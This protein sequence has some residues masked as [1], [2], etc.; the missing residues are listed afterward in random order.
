[1]AMNYLG[2]FE[3]H[4][5]N[6][7]YPAFLALWE[8]YC[9]GDEADGEELKL[10]LQKA[11]VAPLAVPFGRHVDKG[12]ALW[13]RL[14]GTEV[15][16]DVFKLIIDLVTTNTP[17]L[18]RRIFDYL[19][20]KYPDDPYFQDK[21]R[22]IGLRDGKEFQGAV[23]NY[24]LLTHMKKG[25]FVFHN[26]G[27]G[28]GEIMEISFIREQLALEFDYVS[29]CKDLSFQNAFKTLTPLSGDHFL[30]LRFGKPDELEAHARRDSVDVIRILLRDL[31]PLTAAEIKEELH[32][33]VIP[34]EEWARWWQTTRTKIKKSTFIEVPKDMRAPFRLRE[35]EISHKEILRK[36]LEAD[37]KPEKVIGTVYTFLRDFPSVLKEEELRTGLE[38]KLKAFLRMEEL[39]DAVAL[40]IY[41]LLQDSGADKKGEQVHELIRRLVAPDDVVATI[42]I[43][44]FKKR[45]LVVIRSYRDDWKELFLNL[46]LSLDQN[47]LRDYLLSELL[48]V[49]ERDGVVGKLE[50]MLNFPMR[51][52]Y[53][54]L[55]YFKR[56][57]ESP[58]LPFADRSGKERLFESF[59]I[60][61]SL[62]EQSGTYRDLMKKMHTFLTGG[63]Y[64][65]VRKI[66]EHTRIETVREFLLLATKCHSLSDHDLKILRSLAEVVHPSL[67]QGER[68]MRPEED[69]IPTTTEGYEKIRSRLHTISTV[70]TVENA[71]EIEAARALGDLRENAEFK[72]A[73]ERRDRLQGELRMLSEQFKKAR[74]M[75]KGDVDAGAV[76][77]GV[78]VECKGEKGESLSYTFLGPWDVDPEKNILSVQSKLAGAMIG[79]KEGDK[80]KIRGKPFTIV[81]LSNYF[82]R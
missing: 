6:H 28:V 59:F 74:P 12:L 46:L 67:A 80:V 23:S 58:D 65:N 3:K 16:H 57:M 69:F 13:E 22:L 35:A 51:Y 36:A 55:W 15:G 72:A 71:K 77:F 17:D 73:L 39:S 47:P 18:G 70:E 24:E 21:V 38:E 2:Q 1:M 52:P 9:L 7:D 14:K 53:A 56:V 37:S 63:R 45:A 79:K 10:V 82:D 4:L 20:E 42:G 43:V 61:L 49:G 33:L 32:D 48:A 75:T 78:V 11:K 62:L 29:G 68:S 44:A 5:A 8:E 54:L 76:G 41:F 66:F 31:G 40:Q 26:A 64:A 30:A 81:G 27:W 34:G 19:T 25:S 60:L 50:E